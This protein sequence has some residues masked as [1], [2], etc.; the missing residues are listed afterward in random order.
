MA[1]KKEKLVDLKPKAE[2]VTKEELANIQEKVGAINQTQMQIGGLELQK[3]AAF[4]RIKELQMNLNA[5]QNDLKTTY[6]DVSVNL[7]DGT[8][9][10]VE[11]DGPVD[12]KN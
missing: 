4:E 2:K 6:G 11:R 7:N 5:V 1:K 8:L 3:Q 12:Q 9:K 10:Q